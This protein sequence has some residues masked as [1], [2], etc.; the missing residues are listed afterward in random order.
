MEYDIESKLNNVLEETT[1][2]D[3][4]FLAKQETREYIV[5]E[6]K[7]Y[8]EEKLKIVAPKEFPNETELKKMWCVSKKYADD[9]FQFL[10]EKNKIN[11]FYLQELMHCYAK[12]IIYN[13][14]KEV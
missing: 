7:R 2:F 14:L 6:K 4:P 13:I 3:F 5:L 8:V 1:K 11:G 9:Q 10:T 12:K